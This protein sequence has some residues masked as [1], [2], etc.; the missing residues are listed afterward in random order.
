MMAL[1]LVP[2]IAVLGL[3]GLWLVGERGHF[4]LPSTRKAIRGRLD[5]PVNSGTRAGLLTGLHAYAY[6]RWTE[7]YIRLVRAAVPW[8]T[9]AMKRRWAD[10]YHGKVLSTEHACAI[11]QLDHDIRRTDLEHVIPYPRARDILLQGP[12]SVTLLECP[13]RLGKADHCAPTQV[14]MLVGGGDFALDHHPT[15]TRRVTQAEALQVL[16][17]EH[18]RGHVHTAYFKDAVGDRFYAICNC[19]S[20][21]CG[22]LEAMTRYGVPMVASSGFVAEVEEGACVGCGECETACPFHAIRVTDRAEVCWDTC[23]G[24]GVCEG[25]CT[26][27][28]ITLVRDERKGAPLDVRALA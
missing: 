5:G 2:T 27:G 7:Q 21:C 28:A 24:C 12:P 23:M 11:I 8:M 18:A 25:Q 16:R 1:V 26:T 3:A 15:K 4:V 20:C 14:C 10:G 22:G 13:C 6:G 9:P 19:C 17:D